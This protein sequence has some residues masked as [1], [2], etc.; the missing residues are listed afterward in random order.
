MQLAV[1]WRASVT[2]VAV[3][4]M[5]LGST[6]IAEAASKP[7]QVS[8]VAA[9]AQQWAAKAV[10][11]AWTKT[12]GA[13]SY[14]AKW[15][16]D[17]RFGSATYGNSTSTSITVPTPRP[18]VNYYVVVA[19]RNAAGLGAWSKP[20]T[21]KLAPRSVASFG[22]VTATPVAGGVRV[23]FDA[24]PYAS[25]YRVRWSAGPNENRTPDRWQEHYSPWFSAFTPS[26][27]FSYTVPTSD[28][29]LTSV[30]YA[31]PVF[32]RIQARNTYYDSAYVRKSVQVSAWPLPATPDPAG[33][34]MHVASYNV[35]C[36]TCEPSGGSPWSTRAPAIA[37]L[38][39]SVDPDILTVMEANGPS[40][41]TQSTQ[42][43]LD[44]QRRFTRLRLVDP[45]PAPST[46]SEP[47]T[48]IYYDPQLF[49]VTRSG[50]LPG[51]KDY[52]VFP[53]SAAPDTQI[54]WA[55]L[56][57]RDAPATRVIVVA[58]HYGVPSASYPSGK[59]AMLGKNSSQVL[60]ALDRV[61][62]L[63]STGQRLPVVFAGDLNDHRYPE[64]ATDGAQATL[65]RGGFY[66]SA[67][68]QRRVGTAKPTFNGLVPPSR[69]V[70]DANQD[71][72]R[73]DYILTRGFTGSTSFTN[74]WNPGGTVIPSDHNL[75]DAVV[76]LPA[77][78]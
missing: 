9:G 18:A 26:R 25:D 54:P 34:A 75:I 56:V 62:S 30:A 13:T 51:V 20:L 48:R 4:A 39:N 59:K 3:L 58:A 41:G 45:D 10:T 70:D 28:A 11:A 23:D 71:G 32:I 50:R 57:R 47:G 33:E 37:G 42:A 6:T 67:A 43:Y 69:Q 46:L 19:A 53:E 65:V 44:L 60:A 14:T 24:V 63:G 15:S 49:T 78:R 21:V 72:L 76:R 55:E 22:S 17:P 35:L 8:G 77:T 73:I 31:N 66:D 16:T 36:S 64:N 74:R 68:S 2:G 7:A 1:F 5:V 29:D 52:R 12:A 27:S 38:V 40:G 61:D